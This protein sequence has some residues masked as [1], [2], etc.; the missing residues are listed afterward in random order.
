MNRS[1]IEILASEFL[2]GCIDKR[3]F[4]KLYNDSTKDYHFLVIN[5]NSVKNNEDL[6]SIYGVVKTPDNFVK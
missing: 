5:N 2:S 6:D 4:I 3:E 1:S